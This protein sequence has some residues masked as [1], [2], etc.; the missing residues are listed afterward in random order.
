MPET[1]KERNKRWFPVVIACALLIGAAMWVSVL[2]PQGS[3]RA[4]VPEVTDGDTAFP[5]VLSVQDGRLVRLAS[6]G[7]TVLEKY[8][9]DVLTLPAEERERLA[10]GVRVTSEEE[11]VGLIENYTS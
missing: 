11:L 1:A 4:A 7:V 8:E 6:D 9:V 10:D 2:I 5:Q 3:E